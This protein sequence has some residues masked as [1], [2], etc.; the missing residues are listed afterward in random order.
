MYC[1]SETL[2]GA[3]KLYTQMEKVAYAVVMA[4]RKLKH[5]FQAHKITIPSSFLLDNILKNPEAIGR[6][7]KC[8]TEINDIAIEFV[9]RNTIKSQALIDFLVDWT[10]D[11]QNT[12]KV[13]EPIWTVHTNRAWG[14]VGARIAAILTSPS[15]IKLRY[16]ARLEFHCTNNSVEYE[17]IILA[18]SKL[19][20]LSVRRAIIKTDSQVTFGTLRKASK[21]EIPNYKSTY[22]QSGRSRVSS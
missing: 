18:L 15:S 8:G 12:V 14:S 22:T 10:H 19:H 13:T 2:D 11:T 20:A 17:A 5:Y 3:K 7:G 6:I 21:P 4:S 1:V 16:A 9:E